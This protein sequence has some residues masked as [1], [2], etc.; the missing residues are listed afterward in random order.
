[1]AFPFTA[2]TVV[3]QLVVAVADGVPNIN[4]EKGC[5]ASAAADA[6]ATAKAMLRASKR[7]RSMVKVWRCWDFRIQEGN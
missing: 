1:M 7:F 3:A 4:Y 6:S 2:I 5:R